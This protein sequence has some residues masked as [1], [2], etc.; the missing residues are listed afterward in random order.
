VSVGAACASGAVHASRSL[1]AMGR[2]AAEAGATLRFSVG[3]G[4]TEA[5]IDR[6]V[7]LLPDLV[8]RVRESGA[9]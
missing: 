8:A 7:A 5:Q 2:S 1:L 4:V 9:G 3:H 6:V